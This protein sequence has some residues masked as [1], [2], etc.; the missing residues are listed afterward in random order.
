MLGCS[1]PAQLCGTQ[2]ISDS[3]QNR[4]NSSRFWALIWLIPN[5]ESTNTCQ[6]STNIG[7]ETT[8]FGPGSTKLGPKSIASGRMSDY[9]GPIA[10]AEREPRS[11]TSAPPRAVMFYSVPHPSCVD[12]KS[13]R[14][15]GG[16]PELQCG[17]TV[18][19]V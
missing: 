4:P 19:F 16:L 1:I 9:F 3:C 5:S 14:L 13:G 2:S 17:A 15:I 7:P 6:T 8:Q 10:E 18:G 12:A 11:Q